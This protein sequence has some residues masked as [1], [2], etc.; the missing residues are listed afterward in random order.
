M[1]NAGPKI[2][3]VVTP[4]GFIPAWLS[5]ALSGG[6]MERILYFPPLRWALTRKAKC[7]CSALGCSRHAVGAIESPS[8]IRWYLCAFHEA[9]IAAGESFDAHDTPRFD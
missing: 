5:N 4:R 6:W 3:I 9:K 7:F 2:M 1:G 8:R